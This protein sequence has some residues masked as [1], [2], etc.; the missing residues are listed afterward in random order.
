MIHTIKTATL[1]IAMACFLAPS[2]YAGDY[3]FSHKPHKGPKPPDSTMLKNFSCAFDEF[4]ADDFPMCRDHKK[5]NGHWAGIDLGISGYAT[6][7]GDMNF[8]PDHPYMNMNTARSLMVNINPF[9]L[10]LNLLKNKLGFTTGLGFQFSNYQFTGNYVMLQDSSAIV[11]YRVKDD[12][13]NFV[14]LESNKLMVSH[15]TVPLLFEFQTNPFRRTNSF[16]VSVGVI[17]GARIGSYT[18]QEYPE[19][20]GSYYLVDSDG[21]AVAHYET[22]KHTVRERGAYHLDPFKVDAAFRIGW[23]HLNLFGTWSLTKMFQ[24]NEGP[25]LYPFTTGITL[26]GW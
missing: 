12:Q 8:N 3:A 18:K 13:G 11:A 26:V 10:N 17:L 14:K 22:S 2:L 25:E 20:S 24:K 7:A 23:S 6:P 21:T 9:E 1:A 5:F 15:I 19:K 16:H 4:D